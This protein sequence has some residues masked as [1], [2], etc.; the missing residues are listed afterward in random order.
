MLIKVFSF[1]LIFINKLNVNNP[2]VKQVPFYAF[3]I[4]ITA[5][6]GPKVKYSLTSMVVLNSNSVRINIFSYIPVRLIQ[7]TSFF[8]PILTMLKKYV[9]SYMII[10]CVP[11]VTVRFK[12]YITIFPCSLL[13]FTLLS[14][15]LCW[16]HTVPKL[17]QDGHTNVEF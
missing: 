16:R 5:S 10:C 15:P 7:M 8:L 17:T 6:K 14:Y 11:S 4:K 12:F 1:H 2:Y 3:M 13:C 9:L